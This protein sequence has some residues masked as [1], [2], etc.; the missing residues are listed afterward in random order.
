MIHAIII[1]DEKSGIKSL[2]LLLNKF[3]DDVKIVAT[4]TV[5]EEGIDLINQYR[6]DIVFLDIYMPGLNGFDLLDKLTY[7]GFHLIFTTAHNEHGLRALKANAFD[8]LLKPIDWQ[9]LKTAV[10]KVR[11]EIQKNYNVPEIMATIK[12]IF[13][14]QNL[15]IMLPTKTGIEYVLADEIMFIEAH[16][17]HCNI[18]L[19][20]GNSLVV[21]RSLKEYESQLCANSS[22]FF[23]IHN[24][25]IVNI[26]YV[27]RYVKEE[28]GYLTMQNNAHIPVSKFRKERFFKLLNL[29]H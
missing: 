20:N 7:K 17:N 6:P 4:T 27:M 24:S 29:E 26:N 2:E 5:P 3:T 28:G 1:D 14:K 15:K 21:A 22:V 18:Q 19:Q 9:E 16:S 25:F 13:E 12:D 23:R 10:D 8:Y 11:N